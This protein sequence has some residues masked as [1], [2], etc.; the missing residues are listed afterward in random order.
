MYA[1]IPLGRGG[2]TEG[3]LRALRLLQYFCR[4]NQDAGRRQ[5]ASESRTCF[6]VALIVISA[7]PR[8]S[9]PSGVSEH[10]SSSHRSLRHGLS[11]TVSRGKH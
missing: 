5:A 1:C 6:T 8:R 3:G 4:S 7:R 2:R 10:F 11:V 9:A